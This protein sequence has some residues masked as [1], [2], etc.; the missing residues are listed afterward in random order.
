MARSIDK[1]EL[2]AFAQQSGLDILGVAN[3]ERFANAPERMHP[4]AI[5]PEC[6]SESQ[7]GSRLVSSA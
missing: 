6:R 3:I 7:S 4:A 1:Q 2:R 5:Y